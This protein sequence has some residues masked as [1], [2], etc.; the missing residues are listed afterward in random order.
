MR[1]IDG[2]Q[3]IAMALMEQPGR[4]FGAPAPSGQALSL[5]QLLANGIEAVFAT[6]F[7]PDRYWQGRP[8]AEAG[9]EQVEIYDRLIATWPDLLFR[10]AHRGDVERLEA[11]KRLGIVHLME[12]ADPITGP[13]DLARWVAKGVRFIGIVWNS[14]NRYAGGIS[15]RH[16]LTDAGVELLAAM[17][18]AGVVPDLSHL[19]PAA[20][21]DVLARHE[22]LVIASHSNAAALRHHKRNLSDDQIRAVAARDGVVGIVFYNTFVAEAAPT[23]DRVVDHIE[24]MIGLV[25][26][27]HVA[28][29]TDFDGGFGV[30]EVPE[31][32]D[33][34]DALAKLGDRLLGRGHAQD[35]VARILGGN[36][37][38]ILNHALPPSPLEA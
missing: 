33:G 36:W 6:I 26:P 34:L 18:A 29:G 24:H 20:V 22:G 19:N 2:H 17:D 9:W 32:I 25:G 10:L 28:I 12:G 38:R 27:A 11:G 14:P 4:D 30:D 23:I 35:D 37:R 13:E 15:D 1:I 8:G 31:G 7:A 21:D 16:G 5:P 3:D